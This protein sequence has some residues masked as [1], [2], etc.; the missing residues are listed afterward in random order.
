MSRPHGTGAH[1]ARVWL[2]FA[3]AAALPG[4]APATEPPAYVR[5]WGLEGN[6]PGQLA[7]PL[8]VGADSAGNLFVSDSRNNRIAKFHRDGR[9]IAAWGDTGS[10]PGQFRDPSRLVVD[11]RGFVYVADTGNARLQKFDLD[12]N[13][14]EVWDDAGS[15]PGTFVRPF[16]L[17]LDPSGNVYV[18]DPGRGDVLKLSATGAPLGA[19]GSTQSD[20][21]LFHNALGITATAAHVYITEIG[22]Q[23]EPDRDWVHQFTTAGVF[24]R[25]GGTKGE[26]PGQFITPLGVTTDSLGNVYVVDHHNFRLQKFTRDGDFI[27]TW[28]ERGVDPGEFIDPH[29]IVFDRGDLFVTDFADDGQVMHFTYR[30]TALVPQGW[31]D[32]KQRFRAPT[33]RP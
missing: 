21:G 32:V 11:R 27:A 20:D 26:L 18:S 22:L 29:D 8:G 17:A 15:G 16:A 3:V 30:P 12:G 5:R 24:V 14:L 25:R 7:Y 33:R 10:A 28:G 31:G 4:P 9:F 6:G 13:L 2:L 23:G 1:H 19:W